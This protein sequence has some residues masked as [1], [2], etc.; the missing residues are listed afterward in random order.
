MILPRLANLVVRRHATVIVVA[1]VL[2][3]VGGVFGSPVAG[4]LTGGGFTDSQAQSIRAGQQIAAAS[5]V[6]TDSVI[7]VI[8]PGSPIASAAAAAEAAHVVAVLRADPGFATV[9]D[10]SGTHDPSLVSR[11]G[12]ST[13]VVA[14]FRDGADAEASV[15]RIQAALAGDPAVT[16]GGSLIAQDQVGA[17]VGRDLAHAEAL[18]FPI[19]F[20]LL[21][22]V[23]RGLLAALLPLLVG[24]LTI[25]TTFLGLRAVNSFTD[26]SVFALNMVTGLGL[27]L[28]IDYSLLMVSR[29][30]EEMALSGGD[31]AGAVRR[32]MATAG[33]TVLFSS[34]TVAAALAALLVFPQ[35]FLYSMGAGGVIVTLVAAMIALTVLPAMLAALGP[36]IDRLSF[37]RHT[38]AG[39]EHR[40]TW[41]RI[42]KTVMR[43]PV[44]ITLLT[45]GMLVA[46]G[47]PFLGIRFTSV[48][49]SV[50]PPTASARQVDDALHQ[51]FDAHQLSP[52]HIVVTAPP[53]AGAQ[54]VAYAAAVH[55]VAGVS[56]VSTPRY[57]GSSTWTLDAVL[58]GEPLSTTSHDAVVATR[59]LPSQFSVLV[60]GQTAEFADLQDSLGV[61]LPLALLIIAVSTVIVLFAATG[62]VVLPIKSLVMNLAS[63]S[64]TFGLLVL[65][66]Q[67]GRLQS[68]LGY[69]SQGALESTQPIL[70]VAIAFGL[71][72]D[73]GVF[74]LTRIKEGHDAG[75]TTRDTVAHGL[76]RTGRIVTAA[77]LCFTVAIG[78]FA[79]SQIIFI[80]EVGIG[81]A[82]AVLI[83][84]SIVRALLVPS[85]MALL[86][87]WNWWA[88]RPLRW[89]HTRAG[90]ARLETELS[91]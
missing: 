65:I 41:Y 62:S 55:G 47:L 26:L 5:H 6:S 89:L 82:L 69:T 46:L 1:V 79:T 61:H 27:G 33:R 10:A 49:A 14:P 39:A 80:K 64:A 28:A 42:A 36:R 71:S 30:R 81:T 56:S 86:G 11:D 15:S 58:S 4:L 3:V 91:R 50:L 90:L 34:L 8:R 87:E 76:E 75:M 12:Q 45:V 21:L 23:F 13:Y 53:S 48:D 37:H 35:R 32:T 66:F 38:I 7:A 9:I 73:Y 18:A 25:V 57:L 70:L 40:G 44:T 20:V 68:L 16:L 2:G 19:L 51:A 77:A 52:A 67:D 22:F 63:I 83:D 85:L 24:G 60:G 84:A 17:Q 54:I 59:A 31:V 78:A 72:T 29:F 88:P 43:R 74:L